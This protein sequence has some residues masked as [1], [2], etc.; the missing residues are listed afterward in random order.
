MFGFFK[1]LFL[2]FFLIFISRVWIR[3]MEGFVEL[4]PDGAHA[5]P[6]SYYNTCG[7]T[8]LQLVTLWIC[9]TWFANCN[10]YLC[11][12]RTCRS[13]RSCIYLKITLRTV[14]DLAAGVNK[15]YNHSIKPAPSP[16]CLQI[17]EVSC[18][19]DIGYIHS[20]T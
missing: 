14:T 11:W 2:I 12:F 20:L 5:N 6:D 8:S 10:C 9:L 15:N 13:G 3:I 17:T 7:S 4:D 19:L 16:C 1:Y 18:A